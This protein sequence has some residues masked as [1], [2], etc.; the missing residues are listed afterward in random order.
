MYGGTIAET[1]PVAEIFASPQ[2]PYT[3]AL[4]A[5]IP[6]IQ[7]WPERLPTIEGTPPTMVGGVVGCPFEPR[8]AY[9]I[10]RCARERPPLLEVAPGHASACWVAHQGGLPN[11]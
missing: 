10:D 11:V 3:R 9:R 5:S 4:V 8:C 7:D 1:G 6:R 2:H